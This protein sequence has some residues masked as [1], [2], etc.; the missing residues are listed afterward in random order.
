MKAVNCVTV[1]DFTFSEACK[2][3]I[4]CFERVV[5]TCT[6]RNIVEEW[7][8]AGVWPL[9]SNWKLL[10]LERKELREKRSVIHPIFGLKKT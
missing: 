5:M 8:A 1:L 6:G 7:L 2:K 9:S 3:S 10:R 4:H